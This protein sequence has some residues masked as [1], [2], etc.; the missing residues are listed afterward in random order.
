M[1][2][3]SDTAMRVTVPAG[4]TPGSPIDYFGDTGEYMQRMLKI[5]EDGIKVPYIVVSNPP[6]VGGSALNFGLN[7]LLGKELQDDVYEKYG[8][9]KT[10]SIFLPSKIWFTDQNQEE[11]RAMAEG[12]A[13]G[14]TIT[15]WLT[16]DEVAEGYFK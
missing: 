5:N 3:L 8:N 14:D 1:T 7:Q 10:H 13:P 11:Y 16:I 15:Y 2:P 12:M 4:V 9:P 6:G